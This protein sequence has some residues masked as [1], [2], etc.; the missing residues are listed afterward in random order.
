MTFTLSIVQDEEPLNPCLDFDNLGKMIYFHQRY[1]LGDGHN[2]DH[3]DFTG[4]DDLEEYPTKAHNAVIILPLFLYDH[5]GIT[6]QTTLLNA[7]PGNPKVLTKAAKVWAAQ[8]LFS[9]VQRYDPYL[10]CDVWVYV[11][12]AS[13]RNE[14]KSCWGFYGERYCKAEGEDVMAHLMIRKE[15][16]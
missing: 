1:N 14:V 11:I 2:L 12:E 4:W 8:C 13:D 9:E 5:S 6:L 10:T 16:A 15:A 3:S 7:A